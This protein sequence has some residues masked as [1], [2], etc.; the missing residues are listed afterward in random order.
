VLEQNRTGLACIFE[1]SLG[2]AINFFDSE[3]QL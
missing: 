1:N 2:H 3:I